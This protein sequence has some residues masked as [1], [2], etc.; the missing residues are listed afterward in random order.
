M[1]HLFLPWNPIIV[2]TRVTMALTLTITKTPKDVALAG[3]NKSFDAQGGIIGRGQGCAWILPDVDRFLS[4]KH[5]QISFDNGAF[6]L[7]DL[8][9]NGTFINGAPEP[10]GKGGRVIINSGDTVDLGD[11]QFAI[12]GGLSSSAVGFRLRWAAVHRLILLMNSIRCWFKYACVRIG[13]WGINL[14]RESIRRSSC[15]MSNLPA[16]I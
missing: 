2:S 11:Y 10:I 4:S 1:L 5:C 9:T 7:T 14:R 8:S 12:T 3:T 15:F 13:I 6:Y 16:A